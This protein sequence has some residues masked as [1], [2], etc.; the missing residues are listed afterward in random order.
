MEINILNQKACMLLEPWVFQFSKFECCFEWILEY[1]YLR[2]I[3][4]CLQHFLHV[5]YPIIIFLWY[6]RSHILLQHFF[7]SLVSGCWYVFALS[8]PTCRENLLSLFWNVLFWMY[9]LM[10]SQHLFTFPSFASTFWLIAS[11]FI[12]C[13]NC[14]AFLSISK[15]ILMFCSCLCIFARCRRLIICVSNLISH[16]GFDFLF[17]FF[18]VALI[19]PHTY[20]SVALIKSFNSVIFLVGICVKSFIS[21]IFSIDCFPVLVPERRQCSF[22]FRQ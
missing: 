21:F 5:V 12:F 14:V 20:F 11:S 1:F 17:E 2:D 9:C 13:F 22:L 7:P 19:F 4:K 10:L 18:G 8:H 16:P 6:L 15:H 3:I